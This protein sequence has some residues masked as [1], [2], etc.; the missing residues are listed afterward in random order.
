MLILNVSKI[1]NTA[2]PQ[3]QIHVGRRIVLK[4]K[5]IYLRSISTNSPCHRYSLTTKLKNLHD[6]LISMIK[7]SLMVAQVYLF[8]I[9]ADTDRYL[10][11][12]S[13]TFFQHLLF[14]RYAKFT[15]V[16]TQ[17]RPVFVTFLKYT[18]LIRVDI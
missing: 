1:T 18:L 8:R 13:V 15:S 5:T 10:H 14:I 6:R 9:F 16:L 7:V 12:T 11:K 3:H 17:P 2:F 4:W